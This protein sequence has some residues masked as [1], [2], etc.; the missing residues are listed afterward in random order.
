M[1]PVSLDVQVRRIYEPPAVG[2]G[3]RVLVDRRWPRGVSRSRAA[4]DEWCVAIAP[5]VELRRWYAHLPDRHREFCER[6]RAE[7]HDELHAS[8]VRHLQDIAGRTRLT[9]L[10]ATGRLDLSHAVVLADELRMEV[11]PRS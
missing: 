9:L 4:L 3:V 6:Y 5:S 11:P 2:D 8:A 10:T 7:L 1:R